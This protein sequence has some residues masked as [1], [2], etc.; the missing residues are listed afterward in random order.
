[1]L[2]TDRQTKMELSRILQLDLH[3]LVSDHVGLSCSC[4][5]ILELLEDRPG[6]LF[7]V[8]GSYYSYYCYTCRLLPSSVDRFVQE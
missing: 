8:K 4:R 2:R 7:L 6:L 5:E 1:M 3:I